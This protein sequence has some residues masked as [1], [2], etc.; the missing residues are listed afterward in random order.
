MDMCECCM[1]ECVIMFDCLFIIVNIIFRVILDR[2]T[3]DI[4][5]MWSSLDFTIH[6]SKREQ[7]DSNATAT[8]TTTVKREWYILT[9]FCY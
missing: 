7:M 2:Y 6:D 5:D 3:A 8:A 9:I 1:R 4:D